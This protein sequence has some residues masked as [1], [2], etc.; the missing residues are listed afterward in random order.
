MTVQNNIKESEM[1]KT[2]N[3]VIGFCLIANKKNIKKI[4]KA[5]PKKYKPYQIGFISKEKVK[6]KTIGKLQW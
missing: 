1:L 2:F 5:F 3:C 4:K 6:I